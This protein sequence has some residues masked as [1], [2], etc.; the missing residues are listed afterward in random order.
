MTNVQRYPVDLQFARD[1]APR[2]KPTSSS[3][4]LV[5]EPTRDAAVFG[6]W[7]L[8]PLRG[9]P[10]FCTRQLWILS[11]AA[12]SKRTSSGDASVPHLCRSWTQHDEHLPLRDWFVLCMSTAD[13]SE[14][15]SWFVSEHLVPFRN[16][17]SAECEVAPHSHAPFDLTRMLRFTSEL[18]PRHSGP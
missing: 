2:P 4:A 12:V 7:E 16:L 15:P 5:S 1:S 6:Q 8:F 9:T 17:P 10:H 11:T 18:T 13:F 3:A 14:M